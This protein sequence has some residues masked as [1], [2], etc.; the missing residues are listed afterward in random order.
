[1]RSNQLLHL[2]R[3]KEMHD[4]SE[5]LGIEYGIY[6][7]S[8]AAAVAKVLADVFP[9][10][11]PLAVAVGLTSPEFEPFV[12]NCYRWPPKND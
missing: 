10:R 3:G 4:S 7:A 12:R 2:R 5:D 1:L 11:D 6:V 8:E 9:R